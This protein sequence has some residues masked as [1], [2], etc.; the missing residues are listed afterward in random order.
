MKMIMKKKKEKEEIILIKK[1]KKMINVTHPNISIYNT[2]KQIIQ[3][4]TL[5]IIEIV[6]NMIINKTK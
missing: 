6:T 5:F 1:M 2:Q 4:L 3:I